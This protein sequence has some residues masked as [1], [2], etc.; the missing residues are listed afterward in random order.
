VCGLAAVDD[1]R[2]LVATLGGRFSLELG[3]DVEG[4]SEE[5][6]RWALAAT[7]FGN[8]ISTSAVVRTFRVLERA[9][10]RTTTDAANHDRGE[11][12]ALLD[13][14]GYVR[15]DERTADRLIALAGAVLEHCDG[16]IATL[17]ERYTE[18]GE[19]EHALGALPGWGPVVIRVFLREL[20]GVWPGARLALDDRAV[21]AA[22]HLG[23]PA[24]AGPLR[25]IAA[26]AHL[27]YRDLEAALIRL[28]LG[29]DL[30]R[31]PGGE[32]CLLWGSE[33]SRQADD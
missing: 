33:R 26:A 4:G 19:L 28:A 25:G 22:S 16:R 29:H 5:I 12:V 8:R 23:L 30:T 24:T 31:C 21:A 17:G 20:L 9:E 13:E 32:E 1:V 2:R 14:G 18:S 7:L 6:E 27:D 10:V 3:I 15:Y 11:L